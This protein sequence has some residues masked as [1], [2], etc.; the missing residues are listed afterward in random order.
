MK[1]LFGRLLTSVL[2]CMILAVPVVT[3]SNHDVGILDI[4]PQASSYE[5]FFRNF[6]FQLVEPQY[7][8]DNN[9]YP[10]GEA[11][12]AEHVIAEDVEPAPA[13][14]D[15]LKRNRT[16]SFSLTRPSNLLSFDINPLSNKIT[17]VDLRLESPSGEMQHLYGSSPFNLPVSEI[18]EY[19][20][21]IN[22]DNFDDYE[23]SVD[24]YSWELNLALLLPHETYFLIEPGMNFSGRQL[25][26]IDAYLETGGNVISISNSQFSKRHDVFDT[27]YHFEK[28]PETEYL[29][30]LTDQEIEVF[31]YAP[32]A[33]NCMDLT[34][35]P[36]EEYSLLSRFYCLNNNV[37]HTISFVSQDLFGDDPKMSPLQSQLVTALNPLEEYLPPEPSDVSLGLLI[38]W[39]HFFG[40]YSSAVYFILVSLVVF[41][42]LMLF[43]NLSQFTV[44]LLFDY[45]NALT[46]HWAPLRK[47]LDSVRNWCRRHVFLLFSL[48]VLG[49]FVALISSFVSFNTELLLPLLLA[50]FDFTFKISSIYLLYLGALLSIV[51]LFLIWTYPER[52]RVYKQFVLDMGNTLTKNLSRFHRLALFFSF[53]ISAIFLGYYWVLASYF[54]VSFLLLVL[55]LGFLSYMSFQSKESSF[56]VTERETFYLK[57]FQALAVLLPVLTIAL[58]FYFS[59]NFLTI[60]QSYISMKANSNH[61]DIVTVREHSPDHPLTGWLLPDG[62]VWFTSPLALTVKL[63]SFINVK[64]AA[65]S[66]KLRSNRILFA[67]SQYVDSRG[68]S[69]FNPYLSRTSKFKTFEDSNVSL[70]RNVSAPSLP[71][72]KTKDLRWQDYVNDNLPEQSFFNAL[73][74]TSPFHADDFIDTTTKHPAG[75]I[76]LDTNLQVLPRFDRFYTYLTHGFE[77]EFSS[78]DTSLPEGDLVLL[79]AQE[80]EV[81]RG[82]ILDGPLKAEDLPKGT[83]SFY[84]DLECSGDCA[85]ESIAINHIR[86]NAGTL[87]LRTDELSGTQG[88][89]Y[90]RP[91]A[92]H[93]SYESELNF[94]RSQQFSGS[95][96]NDQGE[97]FS[98]FDQIYNPLQLVSL[99]L[100]SSHG[101]LK[102]ST[103]VLYSFTKESWFNPF[104]FQFSDRP[105]LTQYWV[106]EDYE[107]PELEDAWS[108]PSKPLTPFGKRLDSFVISFDY[109]ESLGESWIM[110][111]EFRLSNL[112]S[113]L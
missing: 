68:T 31:E 18:G 109:E 47:S 65:L 88:P 3:A 92:T 91:L 87:V 5:R 86:L 51:S 75:V 60:D 81:Y 63:P 32:L 6:Q 83:Y 97:S 9:L 38:E 85:E 13:L 20:L 21:T 93:M 44:S 105:E 40:Q 2:A 64:K 101:T 71:S 72:T 25:Q 62:S 52:L 14:T 70:Y 36:L 96:E 10:H 69:F 11:V 41:V 12:L 73:T 1:T 58:S 78:P 39:S 46:H 59:G 16:Y 15:S 30:P 26:A 66:A 103:P 80:D 110:I 108:W 27:N 43:P 42:F 19:K 28:T 55:V 95:I 7:H 84:F 24:S 29:S 61:P 107:L 37:P 106:V 76:D 35:M 111:N 77:F 90:L 82:S 50:L 98:S 48:L 74:F 67:G 53:C 23:L 89:F 100:P 56:V 79:S 4:E 94:D 22:G 17:S 112:N 104:L 45:K 33:A 34:S 54:S 8:L 49:S 99:E 57:L 102:S 113:E